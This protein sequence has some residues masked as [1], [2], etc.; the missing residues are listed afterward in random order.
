MRSMSRPRYNSKERG[1]SES[2]IS[3]KDDR[4]SESK[5]DSRREYKNCI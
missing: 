2:T 1:R 5:E 3:R 4:R